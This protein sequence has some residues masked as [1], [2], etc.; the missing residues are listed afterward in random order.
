MH[1][2]GGSMKED[3]GASGS[4]GRRREDGGTSPPPSRRLPVRRTERIW[5]AS[6]LRT[7]VALAS[8]GLLAGC[9]A[10]PTADADASPPAVFDGSEGSGGVNQAVQLEKAYVVMVSIDGFRHDYLDLFPTPNLRR[11]ADRG[12]RARGL[13]PVFPVVTFPNHYSIAT[14]MYPDAHGLVS[15]SFYD[16]ARGESYSLADRTTVEDGSWY[17][18]EPIWVTAE[19]Q[20]MVAASFYWVGSEAPVRGIQPTHWRRFDAG[21]PYETRV[22]QVLEWLSGPGERRPHMVTLYFGG[23]DAVGHNFP[24]ESPE[25]AEAVVLV[26]R[27]IGR[28]MEGIEALPFGDRVYL[29]VVSDHG[30]APFFAE[31]TYHLPDLVEIDPATVIRGVNSHLVL[32]TPGGDESDDDLRDLLAE[33]M[34]RTTVY[35]RGRMP[36]RLH[37]E[38]AGPLL[39]DIIIVPDLGWSVLPWGAAD[40]PARDGY[41]HGWDP[42]HEVMHGVFVAAGPRI[43]PGRR[44]DSFESIHIYP[45]LAE[46]LGLTPNPDADGRLEVLAPIL[47]Y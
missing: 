22:D 27:M 5:H 3:G 7:P 12:V 31:Q 33:A 4:S 38:R 18:G 11:L 29:I 16:P 17:G 20:G 14:G 42:A 15:N 25:L 47:S 26:D 40:R 28:L 9:G 19:T 21:V 45:L 2:A 44:I 6:R 34:P 23:V 8:I 10:A 32:Y 35:R 41:T 37:Y 13:I 39:G 1:L 30:M 36:E 46:L 43:G 24:T